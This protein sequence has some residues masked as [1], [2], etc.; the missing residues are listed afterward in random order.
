[1]NLIKQNKR[2]NLIK[3]LRKELIITLRSQNVPRLTIVHHSY[4][5][6]NN[7]QQYIQILASHLVDLITL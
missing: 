5:A 6:V 4:E 7:S 3:N 1:M 2:L